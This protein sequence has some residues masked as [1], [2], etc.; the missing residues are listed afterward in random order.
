M[1]IEINN[2]PI[3][4][5]LGL[6]YH[7]L[8]K[9]KYFNKNK[10]DKQIKKNHKLIFEL[11]ISQLELYFSKYFYYKELNEYKILQKELLNERE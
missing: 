11:H 8:N 4:V 6:I 1:I 9:E 3:I 10:N 5:N 2:M 7:Y